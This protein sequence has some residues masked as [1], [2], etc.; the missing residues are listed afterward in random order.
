[1]SRK[2]SIITNLTLVMLAVF[3]TA[4]STY[5]QDAEALLSQLCGKVEA[6]DR[7]A[8]QLAQ[9]YE[10]AV[11]YLLPL[12]SAEDVGSRYR[13]QI[14]LQDI[15]SHASRPGAETER[16]TLAQ[17]L[18]GKIETAEVPAAVRNWFIL[19]LERIGKDESVK[20]LTN[21]LSSEDRELRDCA[22]RAL[23]K[24]P[25]DAAAQSLERA[26]KQAS[27]PAWKA[28]LINSLQ[29]RFEIETVV[30]QSTALKENAAA[31]ADIL[32]KGDGVIEKFSSIGCHCF[33]K[34]PFLIFCFF[35]GRG[36][37]G[38]A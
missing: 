25:S 33:I 11:D 7:D 34:K 21:L 36:G 14:T 10:K 38:T 28:A 2:L 9:A 3:T 15:G 5:A 32:K 17:V 6:P 12:M 27:D 31:M 4:Q 22:R 18:C 35:A 13:H 20:T 1:M 24:N 23:E 30:K 29:Q 19:Q 26:M 16:S 8:E 37:R